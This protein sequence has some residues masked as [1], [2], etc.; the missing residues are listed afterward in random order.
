MQLNS[1]FGFLKATASETRQIRVL[2]HDSIIHLQ[3]LC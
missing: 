1:Q 3:V 2:K